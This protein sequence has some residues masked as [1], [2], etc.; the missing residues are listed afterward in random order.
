MFG[1]SL[2]FEYGAELLPN[3]KIYVDNAWHAVASHLVIVSLYLLMM[4]F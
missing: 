2:R 4:K 3:A 1:P